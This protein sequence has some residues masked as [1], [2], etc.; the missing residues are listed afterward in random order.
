M[1]KEERVIVDPSTLEWVDAS[2]MLTLPKGVKAKVLS[3]DPATGRRD[4]LW[5]FP[6]G[7]VEPRHTHKG[8][9]SDVLLQGRWIIEG[10][11]V[12]MGGYIYGPTDVPH[13]P[14]EC[15]EGCL[16]FAHFEGSL[17]HDWPPKEDVEAA[18]ASAPEER[19]ITDPRQLEWQDGSEL[20]TLPKGVK[21]K[22]L[23]ENPATGRRDMLVYFP[24][25]YV[26]PRHTH[27]GTHSDVL[28]QGRWII[29]GTEVGPGGYIY[30]PADVPHGPFE[31]PEGCLVF[32]S[33]HGAP[34][35]DW[36]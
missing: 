34:E 21:M 15:P 6:P 10:I 30:G 8:T 24:P 3:D 13:G 29:E 4:V 1:A 26:E 31:C 36:D 19:V 23:G 27:G 17:E 18:A 28:L 16:V 14:F 25:G 22:M 7:Y 2:E 33:F 9:H 12:E 35:H 11:E 32:G 20:F 5:Y